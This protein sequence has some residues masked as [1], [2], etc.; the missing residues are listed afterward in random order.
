[1]ANESP[2]KLDDRKAKKEPKI[3]AAQKA[4]TV[5]MLL[6]LRYLEQVLGGERV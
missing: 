3:A 4:A 1:V 6:K 5:L 2:I